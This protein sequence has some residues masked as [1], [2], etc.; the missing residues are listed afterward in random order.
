MK[1]LLA[2]TV[3]SAPLLTTGVALA[4]SRYMMN[5]DMWGGGWMSGYGGAWVPILLVA[6]VVGLVVW[7]VKRKGN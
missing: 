5:G 4:Q 3:G 6:V 2:L 1:I 7:V